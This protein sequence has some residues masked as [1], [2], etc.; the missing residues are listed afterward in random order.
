[1]IHL[2]VTVANTAEL[3]ATQAYG[4]GALLRW[5]SAATLG[6]IYTEGGT[7]P[8]VSGTSLYDVWDPAGTATTFYRTRVS[9]AAGSTFSAYSAASPSSL[10]T[11]AELREHVQTALDDEA[12]WRLLDAA[13]AEI[14]EYAGSVETQTEFVRG[15]GGTITTRRPIDTITS[16]VE[17]T[18]SYVPVTLAADDYRVRNSYVHRPAPTR[19][20][21]LDPL[22][23]RC[24][25]HLR[26]GR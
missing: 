17:R 25:D 10:L 12:V 8:L 9:D 11:V 2:S 13:E 26:A 4:A 21:P 20:E 15:G 5:E 24:R 14:I 1:M 16:I 6:G 22:A 7:V 19:H 18:D 23:R 3:L